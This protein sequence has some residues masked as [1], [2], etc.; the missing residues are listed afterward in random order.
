MSGRLA[1]T[2]AAIGL[3]ASAA[4]CSATAATSASSQPASSPSTTH[5]PGHAVDSIS[6]ASGASFRLA[7]V[8]VVMEENHSYSDIVRANAPYFH[9]LIAG[10]A[11]LT[12]YFAIRHPSEPNYLA[13]FSGSTQGLANDSCPH[14]YGAANLASQVR[15]AHRGFIGYSEGLPSVGY[16]GC[17]HG[18]Y[19]RRHVPWTNFRDLPRSVN[20]PLS[21]FPSNYARLPS[22]SF[23]IP[24]LDHDMHD[25]TIAQ[26]DSWL[27]SHLGGYA[28]WARTHNSALIVTWD[29]DDKSE[30]NQVPTIIYGSRVRHTSYSGHADHFTLLRTMEWLY[31]L[32][33]LAH[34]ADRSPITGIWTG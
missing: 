32:K 11:S 14:S 18:R 10:G 2:L 22:V 33:P 1:R 25:G 23:V 5:A 28:S 6:A 17:T 4:A 29:E 21:S 20:Q 34:S 27:H 15:A 19:V 3:L 7:H 8:V 24:N 16:G 9:A 31:G 13:L 30:N 26:A 12:H